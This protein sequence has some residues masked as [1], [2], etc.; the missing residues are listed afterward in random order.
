[1]VPIEDVLN[2]AELRNYFSLDVSARY[3]WV[4][5]RTYLQV[6]ADISN[7]TDRQNQAGID[8][9]IDEEQD[10]G[11]FVITPDRETLLGR[12]SSVGITLSF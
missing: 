9:D 11:G 10:P 4:I 8:Y 12:V 7:I 2:N 6:Y 1:M 5:G 3:G